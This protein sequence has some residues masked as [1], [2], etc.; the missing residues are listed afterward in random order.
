MSIKSSTGFPSSSKIGILPG[1]FI[2]ESA[3]KQNT[4]KKSMHGGL[5][6][7]FYIFT[8]FR[9]ILYF[10]FF[11]F[12]NRIHFLFLHFRWRSVMYWLNPPLLTAWTECGLTVWLA[13]RGLV[14]GLIAAS[15]CC[16][17]YPSLSCVASSWPSSPAYASGMF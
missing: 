3:I 9:Y 7:I 8:F 11:F 13:L 5:K 15:P 1:N 4:K 10:Y 14:S 16:L 12:P 6:D 17:L 2:P